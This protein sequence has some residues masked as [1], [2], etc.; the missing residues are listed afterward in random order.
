MT[1]YQLYIRMREMD[2]W[3]YAETFEQPAVVWTGMM[4]ARA[5]GMGTKVVKSQKVEV[6]QD[7][8]HG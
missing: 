8:L 4:R 6:D 2:R 5:H 3:T 1:Q 7:V